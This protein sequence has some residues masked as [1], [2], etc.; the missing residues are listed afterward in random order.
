MGRTIPSFT[1][2]LVEEESQW[3]P[4]R[5]RLDKCDRNG[6]DDMF[7]IPRLYISSCMYSANP[8]VLHPIILS[9]LFHHYKQLGDLVTRVEA[10][11]GDMIDP[12]STR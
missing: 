3:K 5:Q 2:A 9:V 10:M 4:F 6:F 8:V 11:T 7:S 1:I 12:I